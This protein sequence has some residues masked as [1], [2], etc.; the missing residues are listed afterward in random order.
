MNNQSARKSCKGSKKQQPPAIDSFF[1][2]DDK[3]SKESILAAMHLV[4][5][6]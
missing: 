3:C 6:V 4:V 5:D 2:A 1:W